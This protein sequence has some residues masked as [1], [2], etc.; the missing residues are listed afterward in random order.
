M[1]VAEDRGVDGV[2]FQEE[3]EGNRIVESKER[4][5]EGGGFG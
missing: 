5:G 4:R 2:S 1:A 3:G